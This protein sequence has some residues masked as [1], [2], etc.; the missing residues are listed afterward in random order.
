MYVVT[1]QYSIGTDGARSTVLASAGIP[2]DG[3]Q[4][5]EAFMVHIRADLARFLSTAIRL[6]T[7]WLKHL[8]V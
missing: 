4:L 2:M 8:R 3:E 7:A 1:S 6:R 5:G